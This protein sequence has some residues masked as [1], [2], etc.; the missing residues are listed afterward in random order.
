MKIVVRRGLTVPVKGGPPVGF[1]PDPAVARV[2]LVGIDHPA[3]R[4]EIMVA[5]GD[6]VAVGT[7]LYRDRQR[8]DIVFASPASGTVA[9]I[10]IGARRR[11]AALTIAVEGDEHLRF[12]MEHADTRD[13]VRS[14]MLTSGL[15]PQLRARPYDRI[16]D[17]AAVPDAIFVTAID[18]APHA[19]DPL[20][21]LAE[22]RDDFGRGVHALAH[23]TD[24]PVFVCQP[25]A[26]PLMPESGPIKV[27]RFSGPHPA[28]LAGT[29]IARLFPAL[30]G[31]SVWHVNY[32]DVAALGTLLASGRIDPKRT[33][34]VAG[35][36]LRNPRLLRIPMG[37]DLHALV[38]PD[39]TSGAKHILS[40]PPLGGREARYLSRYHLQA[41]VIDA[42]PSKRRNWLMDALHKAATTPAFIPTQALENTLGPDIAV[43][44]LLRALSIGD[45]EAAKKLGCEQLVEEDMALASYVTG[46]TVDFGKRLREV[47]DTLEGV[48]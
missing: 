30:S 45:A 47:L 41:C 2:G 24:G 35:E 7:P 27:A 22:R 3:M 44:P 48:A 1:D 12:T 5:Q 23:L 10:E 14:V 46:G 26:D 17:P 31:R 43:V 13:G 25:D 6:R 18:T 20:T 33:I 16:P 19:G 32:Q 11:M 8:P 38:R 34:S 36:G 29:H 9:D 42:K 4:A 15:W 39:L 21:V 28:G 40:G 37:T